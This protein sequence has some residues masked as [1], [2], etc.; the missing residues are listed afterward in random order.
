MPRA[1]NPN[2]KTG[3]SSRRCG[4][5][6]CIEKGVCICGPFCGFCGAP[7]IIV[8]VGGYY[9]HCE[10]CQ[11]ELYYKD[12]EAAA[13]HREA[14]PPPPRPPPRKREPLDDDVPF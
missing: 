12:K 8:Y 4:T 6:L 10:S 14:N 13:A 1:G 5:T 9:G 11:P 7:S 3:K 2:V